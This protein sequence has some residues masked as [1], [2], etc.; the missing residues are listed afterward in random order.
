MVGG[1]VWLWAGAWWGGMRVCCGG[2]HRIRPDT[3]NERAVRILLE[4]IL[5]SFNACFYMHQLMIQAQ[6]Y[7]L[8]GIKM[9]V[10]RRREK[11]T[12]TF[13]APLSYP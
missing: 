11:N 1:R 2:V 6:D 8:M 5:V 9:Y 10:F 13:L 12:L 3:V 7:H 4:C